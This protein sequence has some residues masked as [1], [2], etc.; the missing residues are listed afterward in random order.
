[1]EKCPA[2]DD[3]SEAGLART[4]E[5]EP[6]PI[7]CAASPDPTGDARDIRLRRRP[8][9]RRPWPWRLSSSSS[10]SPR[11]SWSTA[12]STSP[13]RSAPTPPSPF[14]RCPSQSVSSGALDLRRILIGRKSNHPAV[15]S[16]SAMNRTLYEEIVPLALSNF[17]FWG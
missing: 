5:L 11:C 9:S 4:V 17:E 12:T 14:A 7:R 6:H 15:P 1:M 3:V 13:K 8:T 2:D 16:I 10:S